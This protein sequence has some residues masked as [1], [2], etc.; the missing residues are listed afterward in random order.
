MAKFPEAETRMFKNKFACKSC[1][2]V[3][4]ANNLKVIA[5]KVS[6][7]KCGSKDLRPLRRK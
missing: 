2:T 5:R 6:C 7:K 3:N 1:K 4:K